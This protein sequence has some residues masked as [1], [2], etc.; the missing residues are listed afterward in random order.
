MVERIP[1]IRVCNYSL[2]YTSL[3]V[4]ATTASQIGGTDVKGK[5]ASTIQLPDVILR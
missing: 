2:S 4:E 5:Q 1:V 3:V